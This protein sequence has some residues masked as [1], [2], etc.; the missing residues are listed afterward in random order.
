VPGPVAAAESL[1]AD[2]DEAAPT[3]PS[4]EIPIRDTDEPKSRDRRD[5]L[6]DPFAVEP[7]STPL[8]AGR[9]D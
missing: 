1:A 9:R 2:S 3:Q 6:L 5:S 7:R 4:N 8:P